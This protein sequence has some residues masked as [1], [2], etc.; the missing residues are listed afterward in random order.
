MLKK[1]EAKESEK[2]MKLFEMYERKQ[3]LKKMGQLPSEM[4][5]EELIAK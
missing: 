1:R 4:L 5:H 2:E 3:A